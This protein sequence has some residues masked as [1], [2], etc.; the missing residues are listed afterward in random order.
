M[1]NKLV[2]LLSG[3]RADIERVI[4]LLKMNAPPQSELTEL[5]KLVRLNLFRMSQDTR[6]SPERPDGVMSE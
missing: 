4:E 3:Q 2:M 6:A 5:G 1:N